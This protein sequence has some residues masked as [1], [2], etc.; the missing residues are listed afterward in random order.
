MVVELAP[1]AAPRQAVRE[2]WRGGAGRDGGALGP[3]AATRHR[4]TSTVG[5]TIRAGCRHLET[6]ELP[7]VVMPLATES[8]RSV[9]VHS[10]FAAFLNAEIEKFAPIAARYGLPLSR[11]SS[12]NVLDPGDNALRMTVL[13]AGRRQL[14]GEIPPDTSWHEVAHLRD[15][16]LDEI[17]VIG[18]CGWDA[19]DDSDENELR[20]VAARKLL[21]SKK[22]WQA[23]PAVILWGHSAAGPFTILEG[24]NR[25]VAYAARPSGDLAIPV[26][27]GISPSFCFW[28]RLDPPRLL[29]HS[30][31]R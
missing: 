5:P 27:V 6:N 25:L 3:R 20:K 13:Y 23:W 19:T 2:G 24:N 12:P 1:C 7:L 22:P 10:V 28:H 21:P 14:L 30:F 15:E 4:K 29:L 9:G 8:W 18:R 16:H 31:W 26:L 11:I 17:R